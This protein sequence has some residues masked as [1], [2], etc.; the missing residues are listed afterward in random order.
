MYD[1]VLYVYVYTRNYR[2]FLFVN[3]ENNVDFRKE[4]HE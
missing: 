3:L 2:E 1:K 4:C